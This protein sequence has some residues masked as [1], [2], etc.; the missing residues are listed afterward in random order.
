M[1]TTPVDLSKL[2]GV[3]KNGVVKKTKYNELVKNVN[4]SNT[5][6]T[7]NLVKKNDYSTKINETENKVTT[8]HD[9]K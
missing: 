1:A 4:N 3:V 6:D 7:I 8:D 2:R 5:T 9:H